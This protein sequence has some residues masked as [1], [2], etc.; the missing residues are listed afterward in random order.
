MKSKPETSDTKAAVTKQVKRK[1]EKETKGMPIF[2]G[3][4]E[5]LKNL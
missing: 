5:A 3:T 4:L 2:K 1:K